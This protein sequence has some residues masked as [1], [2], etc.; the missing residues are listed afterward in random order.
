MLRRGERH[1]LAQLEPR[2]QQALAQQDRASFS[3][4]FDPPIDPALINQPRTLAEAASAS[5]R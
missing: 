3:R 5:A 4:F 2:Q 1:E